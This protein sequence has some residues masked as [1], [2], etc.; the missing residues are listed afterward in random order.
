MARLE[1]GHRPA[2]ILVVDFSTKTLQQQGKFI[3]RAA[4]L[5]GLPYAKACLVELEKGSALLVAEG[6]PWCVRSIQDCARCVKWYYWRS[7][8]LEHRPAAVAQRFFSAEW[9]HRNYLTIPV[10]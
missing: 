9:L 5:A 7:G 4:K 8:F 3:K 6:I 2:A 1:D 10:Q